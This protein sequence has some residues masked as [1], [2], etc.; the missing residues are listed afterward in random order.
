[1]NLIPLLT[2][3]HITFFMFALGMTIFPGILLQQIAS[4]GDVAAIRTAFRV[5]MY[6]GRV[7]GML[8][9]I[10]VLLGF[11]LAAAAHISL[12]SGWLIAVYVV[13]IVLTVFGVAVHARHEASI[14]EAASSGRA[15]AGEECI[16]LAR[17]PAQQVLNVISLLIWIFAIY[18]MVAK[19]F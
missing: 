18:D 13:V 19:P 5:G 12:L 4:T 9:G 10:G 8:V 7:G 3:F 1:V 15:D 11:G 2:F 17:L 16:R 6:H 14:L